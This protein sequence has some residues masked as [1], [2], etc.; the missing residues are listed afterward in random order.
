MLFAQIEV[1]IVLRLMHLHNLHVGIHGRDIAR[2]TEILF[3]ELVMAAARFRFAEEAVFA[4]ERLCGQ[5]EH[6]D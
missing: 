3:P 2:H 4:L 1:E 6:R 5:A